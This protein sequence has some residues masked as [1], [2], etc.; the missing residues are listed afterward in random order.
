[1]LI[2]LLVL[3]IGLSTSRHVMGEHAV[4]RTHGL[5]LWLVTAVIAL[6]VAALIWLTL[7]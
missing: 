7:F 1:M 5:A 6:S 3:I 2:P 4:G